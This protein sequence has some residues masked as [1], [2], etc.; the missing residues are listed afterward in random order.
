MI[1]AK[2]T[3]VE[4]TC[5]PFFVLN[6]S[7]EIIFG[8][9]FLCPLLL[10]YPLG[11]LVKKV[12]GSSSQRSEGQSNNSL[13]CL[14]G[15]PSK[16]NIRQTLRGSPLI[17]FPLFQIF[18]SNGKKTTDCYLP[19]PASAKFLMPVLLM[20]RQISL[21]DGQRFMSHPDKKHSKHV[22]HDKKYQLTT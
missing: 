20:R 6:C 4:L 3:P 16:R 1:R 11:H 10:H 21:I 12:L 14:V 15:G 19:K 13:T 5:L 2:K 22:L 18:Q 9:S 17:T 8:S 7:A